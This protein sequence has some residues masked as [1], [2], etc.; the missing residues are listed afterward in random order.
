MR[1]AIGRLRI[2]TSE[3]VGKR[4]CLLFS[5]LNVFSQTRPTPF[6]PARRPRSMAADRSSPHTHQPASSGLCI[7]HAT[8][9][10][11]AGSQDVPRGR[12]LPVLSHHQ[13]GSP[14]PAGQS[15][16]DLTRSSHPDGGA[17]LMNKETQMS[18][19]ITSVL[20]ASAH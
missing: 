3:W 19:N 11:V 6:L 20:H 12:S 8:G 10:Y 1:R 5:Y 14:A 17:G 13:P 16:G 9:V 7:G 18:P 4:V 2:S 15:V